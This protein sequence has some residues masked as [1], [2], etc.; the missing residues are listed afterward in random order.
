MFNCSLC[1]EAS[2][3]HFG[4]RGKRADLAKLLIVAH[5]PDVRISVPV[6]PGHDEYETTLMESKTGRQLVEMLDFCNLGI[7]DIYWTNIF[8][9]CLPKT[10][11]KVKEGMPP[12]RSPRR[13]EYS[14]CFNSH[15]LQQFQEFNPRAV[16]ALGRAVY[17]I[18]FPE[19][20]RKFSEAEDSTL[21]FQDK[22]TLIFA[23][24]STFWYYSRERREKDYY[25]VLKDFLT[26]SGVI[27]RS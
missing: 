23:H 16:V 20:K 1:S 7:D 22:L 21:C 4:L 9:C 25:Q 18:M 15:F 8:K 17:S 13:E 27:Q 10:G 14:A 11:R 12:D 26:K 3:P 19:E 6:L 5:R 24:P 2:N